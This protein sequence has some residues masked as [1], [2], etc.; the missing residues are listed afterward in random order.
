MDSFKK[1][2]TPHCPVEHRAWLLI[3]QKRIGLGKQ[4][5]EAFEK[6]FEDRRQDKI[7]FHAVNVRDADEKVQSQLLE[8]A[9]TCSWYEDSPQE[10]Q[11]GYKRM[12]RFEKMEEARNRLKSRNSGAGNESKI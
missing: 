3:Y 10:G 12:K 2:S 1:L 11:S 5:R 8:F 6:Q 4:L 7:V 9:K